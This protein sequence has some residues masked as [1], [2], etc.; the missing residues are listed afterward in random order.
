MFKKIDKH[1]PGD[2]RSVAE[3]FHLTNE[4]AFKPPSLEQRYWANPNSQRGTMVRCTIA[5]NYLPADPRM[6]PT[7]PIKVEI[8]TSEGI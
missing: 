7:S 6:Y 5:E 1:M 8:H 4:D 3:E 2:R